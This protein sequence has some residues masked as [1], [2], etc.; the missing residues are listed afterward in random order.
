MVT[1]PGRSGCPCWSRRGPDAD[2]R[3]RLGV[4][5]F[6]S[7]PTSVHPSR[8]EPPFSHPWW[9]VKV[10]L[11]QAEPSRVQEQ[12]RGYSL[13]SSGPSPSALPRPAF[14]G[15]R[16]SLGLRRL[17]VQMLAGL[18]VNRVFVTGGRG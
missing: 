11:E 16:G 9:C 7:A 10:S 14:R 6:R 8:W 18:R 3:G 1:A 13:E 2:E 5:G 17:R 15:L 12:G 4:A